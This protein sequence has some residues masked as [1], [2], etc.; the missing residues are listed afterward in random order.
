MA[1]RY[2]KA[3]VGKIVSIKNACKEE[4]NLWCN[5]DS[6][7]SDLMYI[8]QKISNEVEIISH[9][10][11]G[12]SKIFE[13]N[14]EKILDKAH[15]V[16]IISKSACSSD[17]SF[18]Q[19]FSTSLLD[20][21]NLKR[22]RGDGNWLFRALCLA[23][24]GDDSVHLF[25]R[26]YVWDYLKQHLKNCTIYG[27]WNDYR[28]VY[29]KILME[30]EWGGHSEIVAFSEIYSIQIHIF[31]S[32]ASQESITRVV[33]ADGNYTISILFSGDHYDCLIPKNNDKANRK[34]DYNVDKE[35]LKNK[36]HADVKEL[37]RND[38]LPNDY[39]TK[40]F[41]ETLKSI[42]EYLKNGKHHEGIEEM[43]REKRIK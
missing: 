21:Y 13:L 38:N 27:W 24:F 2:N 42:L 22:V 34:A 1:S 12:K 31:D 4:R 7:E 41:N 37:I 35:D 14:W 29:C 25:V 36:S 6:E 18:H 17:L 32:I 39:P 30:G 19:D 16:T 23:T 28:S 15:D 5:S 26:Q 20:L 9:S 3:N 43:R 10:H 33:T 8:E 40:Y 11:T